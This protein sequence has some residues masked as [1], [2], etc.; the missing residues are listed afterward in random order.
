MYG[1]AG[2]NRFASVNDSSDPSKG[3]KL[4]TGTGMSYTYPSQNN[5][6]NPIFDSGREIAS[7]QYNYLDLPT[8]ISKSDVSALEVIYDANGSKLGQMVSKAGNATTTQYIGEA[9]L[10]D[11]AGESI[12]NAEGRNVYQISQELQNMGV[13]QPYYEWYQ[14]D[15]IG[16]TRVRFADLDGSGNIAI[17]DTFSNAI[18]VVL[19]SDHSYP[20]G[21]QWE[22]NSVVQQTVSSQIFNF[23]L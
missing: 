21:L 16:N 4:A 8:L 3:F 7:I 5:T 9:E 23:N 17:G 14:R 20:F 1:Y 11:G 15:H 19:E 18:N 10:K 13:A 22:R 2:N 12:Y 6:G